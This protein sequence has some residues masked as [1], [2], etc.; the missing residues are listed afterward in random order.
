MKKIFL[1]LI[2]FFVPYTVFAAP[3]INIDYG[4]T[5]SSFRGIGW[6]VQAIQFGQSIVDWE[7]VKEGLD[8]MDMEFARVAIWMEWWRP[9]INTYTFDN[10]NLLGVYK[11][12]EYADEHNIDVLITNV[13]NGGKYRQQQGY[14]W[15]SEICHADP[16]N[17]SSRWYF[18][19]WFGQ[20]GPWNDHPYSEDEFGESIAMLINHLKNVKGFKSV[21]YVSIWGEPNLFYVSHCDNIYCREKRYPED[22]VILY[23]KVREHMNNYNLNSVALVSGE[24]SVGSSVTQKDFNNIGYTLSSMDRY[25]DFVSFHHYNDAFGQGGPMDKVQTQINNNNPDGKKERIIVGE[26]GASGILVLRPYD[27]ISKR[28]TNS[29]ESVKK[30]IADIKQGAYAVARWGYNNLGVGWNAIGDFP[31]AKPIPEAFNPYALLSA[32]T[33]NA[34]I[35]N[36]P[37]IE[38]TSA[39]NYLDAVPIT[40]L[41]NGLKK[42]AVWLISE[43]GQSEKYEIKI[44]FKNLN[45]DINL[46]KYFID[47]ENS[48]IKKGKIFK[49]TQGNSSLVD[50]EIPRKGIV[51]YTEFK[52]ILNKFT[53]G[54]NI[55]E[56][57][58]TSFNCLSDCP[59]EDRLRRIIQPI[60]KAEEI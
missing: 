3:E 5:T 6:N 10:K 37:K 28:F 9:D 21:K 11:F 23:K 1:I 33:Y 17:A 18:D 40:F 31:E 44:N 8:K 39:G 58:E 49:L 25:I 12:L 42:T 30:T 53:C 51:V 26:I 48:V 7:K 27:T 46:Q 59:F 4:Q 2:L 35:F 19:K 54:N 22:F 20:S 15:N 13:D 29:F 41:H 60:T 47:A 57:G 56:Q 16:T 43:G 34:G 24:D 32:S 36:I 45:R 52:E 14:W 38:M 55:C 50:S